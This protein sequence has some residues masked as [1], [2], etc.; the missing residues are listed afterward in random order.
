MLSG[1]RRWWV[2][3]GSSRLRYCWSGLE[4]H[5]RSGRYWLGYRC[6]VDLGDGI[7][8][9]I[10]SWVERDAR[11]VRLGNSV[12]TERLVCSQLSYEG[13]ESLTCSSRHCKVGSGGS[14]ALGTRQRP[15]HRCCVTV[16]V[17]DDSE[18]LRLRLTRFPSSL[19]L[20]QQ[21]PLPPLLPIR[22]T[23]LRR[24]ILP[25]VVHPH[26][27]Q[28]LTLRTH[29]SSDLLPPL[30]RVVRLR[31]RLRRVED[32]D[33]AFLRVEPLGEELGRARVGWEGGRG[34]GGVGVRITGEVLDGEVSGTGYQRQHNARRVGNTPQRERS[35][36]PYISGP[37]LSNR[38]RP[39]PRQGRP[40]HLLSSYPPLHRML[41]LTRRRWLLRLVERSR[42]SEEGRVEV[43]RRARR[44]WYVLLLVHL[45]ILLLLYVPLVL[46]FR[47]GCLQR[48][49][50]L[51]LL[52]RLPSRLDLLQL[53]ICLTRFLLTSSSRPE[54]AQLTSA[55]Y[56][57]GGRDKKK[58]SLQVSVLD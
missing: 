17:M 15:S 55:R 50:C 10:Y 40:C 46:N 14:P 25:S 44:R 47:F 2:R 57:G 23:L 31:S 18:T 37:S 52:L 51:C 39:L 58:S 3:R 21:T 27:Q 28:H 9:W 7:Y 33:H 5:R 24:L 32:C 16:S 30:M 49:L 6:R 19:T 29:P 1:G 45:I 54:S 20:Q 22:R 34:E 4:D 26:A 41:P 12:V 38:E 42:R 13:G 35:D 8:L 36:S 56:R 43:S 53:G 48:C 11:V